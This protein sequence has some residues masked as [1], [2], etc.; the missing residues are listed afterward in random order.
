MLGQRSL[1]AISHMRLQKVTRPGPGCVCDS[2]SV[3]LSLLTL[4]YRKGM[5]LNI[6][7]IS[8]VVMQIRIGPLDT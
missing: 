5:L 6:D 8:S 7:R 2:S 4:P 3:E 1:S